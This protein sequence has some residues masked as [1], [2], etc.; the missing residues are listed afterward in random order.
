MTLDVELSRFYLFLRNGQTH[1]PG[2]PLGLGRPSVYTKPSRK[3]GPKPE[4]PTS[5]R[6]LRSL[7]GAFERSGPERLSPSE[8]SFLSDDIPHPMTGIS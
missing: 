2:Q 8:I 5:A 1:P 4:F 3:V 7:E 6:E